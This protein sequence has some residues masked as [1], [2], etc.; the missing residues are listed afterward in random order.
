MKK[1]KKEK[2]WIDYGR[3]EEALVAY[4]IGYITLEEVKILL[5]SL[6]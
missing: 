5:K 6:M 3:I 1:N 2:N 4:K